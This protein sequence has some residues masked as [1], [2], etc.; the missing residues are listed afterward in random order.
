MDK[1]Q[2]YSFSIPASTIDSDGAPKGLEVS[3]EYRDQH[4]N[5]YSEEGK[6]LWS[7]TSAKN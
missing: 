3:F 5:I 2:A 4:D 7:E 6:I 1:L